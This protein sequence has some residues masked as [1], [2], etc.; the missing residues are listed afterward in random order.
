[1]PTPVAPAATT[2]LSAV[3]AF[4]VDQAKSQIEGQGFSN[5]SGLRKDVK[6][7]W[8]GKAVKDGLPVNVTLDLN[9]NVTA[10]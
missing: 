5:V 6:G 4:T 9:G 3:H 7:I 2:S 1:V 10:N 8:R